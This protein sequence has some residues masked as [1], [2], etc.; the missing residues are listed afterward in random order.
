MPEGKFVP[1]EN[2]PA[3]PQTY[4]LMTPLEN[5]I[6]AYIFKLDEMPAEL[7]EINISTKKLNKDIIQ[8]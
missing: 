3:F 7:L 8:N 5:V 4:G 6:K 2:N 1:L